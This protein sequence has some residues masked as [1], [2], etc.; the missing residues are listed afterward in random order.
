MSVAVEISVHHIEA[1]D[2]RGFE[3]VH[4]RAAIG[5]KARRATLAV[6]QAAPDDGIAVA[7]QSRLFH[8]R[9]VREQ[10]LEKRDLH[11]GRFGMDAG[12]DEPERRRAAAVGLGGCVHVRA[13]VDQHL[14]DLDDVRRRFLS[15]ILD[16]VRGHVVQQR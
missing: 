15:E 6:G 11:A 10:Q 2:T 16:A 7:G 1:A 12:R 13:S 4:S 3:E 14:G 8:L 5:K 9:P